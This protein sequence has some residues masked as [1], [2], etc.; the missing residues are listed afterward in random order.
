MN[1][2]DRDIPDEELLAQFADTGDMAPMERLIARYTGKV[3]NT[4]FQ[5][6]GNAGDADDLTQ[7]VFLRVVRHA[8][9]FNGNATFATWLYR[10]A[11]NTGRTHLKKR[12]RSP[13][14]GAAVLLETHMHTERTARQGIAARETGTAMARAL[15][16]LSPKLRTAL[17]LVTIQDMPVRDVAR[18]EKCTQATIHW[19]V[20]KARQRLRRLLRE[21]LK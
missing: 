10:I 5:L 9:T 8:Q 20:F 2:G 16:T 7:E 14:H 18:I 6:T 13:L 4:M 12:L 1:N 17:V 19:R 21:H 15:D 3:R 11:V